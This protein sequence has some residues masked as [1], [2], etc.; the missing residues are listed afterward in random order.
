[1][2]FLQFE[3]ESTVHLLANCTKTNTF[4]DNIKELFNG[5]LKLPSLTH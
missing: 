5:K 4:W 2:F 3:E 1:M